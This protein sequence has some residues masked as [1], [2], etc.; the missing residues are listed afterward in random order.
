MSKAKARAAVIERDG[1][2]CL[3]CGKPPKGLHLHRVIYG[4]QGG[5]YE[6]GNCVLLCLHDHAVVHSTKRLWQPRL[7]THLADP[8]ASEFRALALAHRDGAS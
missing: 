2:W 4:S 8:A 5:P 7:L 3:L 6:V 1:D